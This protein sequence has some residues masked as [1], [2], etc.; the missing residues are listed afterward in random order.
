V[1]TL[2]DAPPRHATGSRTFLPEVQ[3]LRALAVLLVVL[4]HFWPLRLPGGFVGVDVFFVI[5]GFLITSH[6]HREVVR[7]GRISLTSFYAR[8]A[9]RLLP[10]SLLVLLATAVGSALVLPVTRWV[11]TAGDILA[12]TFYVQ[13]WG[14]AARAVDYSA[15]QEAASAVQH[16]WSLSVEEQFY[17]GWPPL[18]LLLI[19][20]AGRLP[21]MRRDDVLLAGILAV[22]VLSLG[23][24]IHA[25]STD[26]AAA[27]FV[28]PTRLWELGAGAVL[29]LYAH[30]RT[31]PSGRAAIGLRWVGLAAIA[32]AALTFSSA[33]PFPGYLALIPVLGTVAV[34]AAGDTGA[35]DPLSPLMAWRPVQFLGDV[36]YSLYLWHWPVI[37]L[38]PFVLARP[39]TTIDKLFFLGVCIGLAW[40]TKTFVEGPTQRWRW[41][42]R[43]RVTAGLTAAAMLVVAGAAGLQWYEVQRREAATRAFLEAALRDPCFGAASLSGDPSCAADVFASPGWVTPLPEDAPWFEDPACTFSDEPVHLARCRFGDG[44]PA[45]TVALVGDSHAEHW[46]G[47]LHRIAEERNWELVEVLRGGCPATA[48]TVA[49]FRGDTPPDVAECHHWG[50]QVDRFLAAESPDY[51]FTSAWAG[52]YTF[53]GDEPGT[54]GAAVQGFADTWTDWAATG[55]QVFVLRDVPTTGGRDMP[56]CLA[57]HPGAPLDCARPRAEA[58]G[59]DALAEAAVQVASDRIQ[60]VDLTDRFCD[61]V[62]CYAAVG[63][64]MVYYDRD[65]ISGLYSW[66]LGPYL[67]ERISGSLA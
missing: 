11:S 29:A 60:L 48:A 26:P 7:R 64:S 34:I 56:E 57:T 18:I 49:T 51:V 25:T 47:A 33:T 42:A 32:G 21:R 8:R 62:T 58:L 16:F 9:R 5:S 23:Y 24:S 46:R 45:R 30:G 63:R 10:A 43:P 13:N 61:D 2:P 67:D 59:E 55:A 35:R 1:L 14:L 37:V 3:A 4:Y 53:E 22:S 52:A 38:T 44:P 15:A 36:S 27:Y 66:S 54:R 40:A 31:L 17:L 50:E 20:L 28:T 6:L 19:G 65:H 41:F 39:M 12:S